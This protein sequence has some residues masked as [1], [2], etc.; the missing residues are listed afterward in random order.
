MRMQ[1]ENRV[2]IVDIRG[3]DKTSLIEVVVCLKEGVKGVNRTRIVAAGN[4]ID[5][6]LRSGAPAHSGELV[7]NTKACRARQNLS[8]AC[9]TKLKHQFSVICERARLV[10]IPD[11]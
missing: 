11:T 10:P 4:C 6:Q 9:I 3:R 1:R 7:R 5:P 2:Q 8:P